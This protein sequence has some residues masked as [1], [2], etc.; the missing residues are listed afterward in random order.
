MTNLQ[1]ITKEINLII[2]FPN[3][4]GETDEQP[5]NCSLVSSQKYGGGYGH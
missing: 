2:P 1:N 3:F 4:L 5:A